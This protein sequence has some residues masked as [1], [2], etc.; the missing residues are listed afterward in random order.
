MHCVGFSISKDKKV[1]FSF[2]FD[3]TNLVKFT[4]R[5]LPLSTQY[6]P[7][8]SNWHQQRQ[9]RVFHNL[10]PVLIEHTKPYK[11]PADLVNKLMQEGLQVQDRRQAEKIIYSHNYFRLKAYFIPFMIHGTSTFTPG[12]TFDAVYALYQADQKIRDFLFPII[13]QLEIRIRA[14]IDNEVTKATND[15]FWHLNQENFTN[16][17][18]IQKV[19]DKAGQRFEKGGQEFALH[20]MAKYYN[21]KSYDY[22]RIPPF[23]VISEIFTVNQH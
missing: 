21:K 13:A 2:T 15:P 1:N 8:I 14:V 18:E 16:F 9:W 5:Y 19:L 7:A 3:F 12:T 23:W 4:D 17:F 10:N 11:A 22:C 6:I 20:H